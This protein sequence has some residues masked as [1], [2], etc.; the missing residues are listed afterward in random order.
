MGSLKISFKKM[1][2]ATGL[3]AVIA[4]AAVFMRSQTVLAATGDCS[5]NSIIRCGASSPAD[6]IAKAR[7][8]NP[9]DL[10]AIYANFKLPVEQYD[11]FARDAKMGEAHRNGDITING[12]VVGRNAW[13][14]GRL[15]KSYSTPYKVGNV[16]Y[17]RSNSTDVFKQESLPA[18]LWFDDKG[19]LIAGILTDCGNPLG[20]N[21]VTPSYSC[22]QLNK[23]AV[24]GQANTYRFTANAPASNG[25]VISRVVYDFGDG[26]Q[27][28][29]T[30]PSEAVTHTYS[31]AGSYTAKVTIYFKL[32][33]GQEVS[34]SGSGCATQITVQAPPTPKVATWQCTALQSARRES[35]GQYAYTFTANASVANARLV[36]VDFNFGDGTGSTGIA[37]ANGANSVAVPHTYAGPGT[38]TTTATLH[39]RA[40]DGTDGQGKPAD[41]TCSTTVTPAAPPAAELPKTGPAGI[42]GLFA[43]TG[44]LGALGYRWRASRK[45]AKVDSVVDNLFKR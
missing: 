11:A 17:H 39:F 26:K 37:P 12:Q 28:T 3:V 14:I 24:N 40:D 25:A 5:D 21:T 30:N 42:V 10:Q 38:Y 34:A 19:K 8:N 1:V 31:G 20:G 27:E 9:N 18:M 15:E 45:L 44:A 36:N 23:E 32:P 43:G 33:S 22:N 13:S 16:T 29:R 41:V 7:A 2:L 35:D 6:L 4:L